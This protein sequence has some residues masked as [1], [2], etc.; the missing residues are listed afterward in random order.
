MTLHNRD[1]IGR[2]GL[3]VGDRVMIQRAGDVIPQVVANLTAETPR[4]PYAFPDTCPG[5]GSEAVAAEGEVDVRCTGGPF[6]RPST[7]G[8]VIRQPRGDGHRGTRKSI[9]EF[10]SSCSAA[11][12]IAVSFSPKSPFCSSDFGFF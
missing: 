3:R 1:E 11:I 7:S 8:C 10:S 6:A 2:L 5:R 12:S 9:R 4:T